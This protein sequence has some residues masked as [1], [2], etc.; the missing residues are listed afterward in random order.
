MGDPIDNQDRT[1]ER[2]VGVDAEPAASAP[3]IPPAERREQRKIAQRNRIVE[4]AE[5]CFEHRGYAGTTMSHIATQ[6]GGSKGTL[7]K[8]FPTKETLFTAVVKTIDARVRSTLLSTLEP[9]GEPREVLE[10][11]TQRFIEAI[12]RNDSITLQRMIIAES[13]RFPE[14]GLIF[15]AQAPAATAELLVAYIDQL[16]SSRTM[17]ADDPHEATGMLLALASGGLHQR[18]LWGVESYS[19]NSARAEAVLIVDQLLRVY[20]LLPSHP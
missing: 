9:G 4:V 6:L 5:R 2:S 11:F 7:W 19:R 13:N 12:S 14:I 18:I 3:S 1:D 8:H 15:F 17:R 20:T 16:M 10:K